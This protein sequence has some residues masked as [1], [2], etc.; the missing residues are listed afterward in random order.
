[1]RLRRGLGRSF[2][3]L[4]RD[5]RAEYLIVTVLRSRA[6]VMIA[7]LHEA[8]ERNASAISNSPGHSSCNAA[9]IARPSA[10]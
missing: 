9:A 1:M 8:D 5:V 3:S 4:S 6:T 10:R 2:S 7:I